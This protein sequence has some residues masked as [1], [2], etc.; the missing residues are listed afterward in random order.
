MWTAPQLCT[1]ILHGGLPVIDKVLAH[2]GEMEMLAWL[3]QVRESTSVCQRMGFDGQLL[4][5]SH[6]SKKKLKANTLSHPIL[7]RRSQ[8]GVH[9]LE[10]IRR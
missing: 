3:V 2:K 5:R 10:P 4:C 6:L 9:F 1:R 7:V 8:T